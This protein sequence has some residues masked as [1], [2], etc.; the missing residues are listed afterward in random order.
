MPKQVPTADHSS[1]SP[2]INHAV[3]QSWGKDQPTTNVQEALNNSPTKHPLSTDVAKK[4]IMDI[5]LE[6]EE[7]LCGEPAGHLIAGALVF[8]CVLPKGHP[9]DPT[10]Y[11]QGHRSGGNCIAHGKYI[12]FLAGCQECKK[13]NYAAAI[14][15]AYGAK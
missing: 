10:D 5:Q 3:E 8:V 13:D 11:L 9:I 14:R 2:S 15:K 1:P 12:D 7:A 4:Q 6:A